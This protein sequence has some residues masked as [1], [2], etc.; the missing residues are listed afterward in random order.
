[1][2]RNVRN[3]YQSNLGHVINE[4]ARDTSR[5]CFHYFNSWRLWS[6]QYMSR[7]MTYHLRAIS[8]EDRDTFSSH[9]ETAIFGCSKK[10]HPTNW[11]ITVSRLTSQGHRCRRS[12]NGN[13]T[14]F[15]TCIN[16]ATYFSINELKKFEISFTDRRHR[17]K[18]PGYFSINQHLMPGL[19]CRWRY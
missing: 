7:K 6:H 18:S 4:N 1:M 10:N 19:N 5:S 13:S 2:L 11:Q 9:R 17:D 16:P 14:L 8:G 3:Q 15:P 12:I